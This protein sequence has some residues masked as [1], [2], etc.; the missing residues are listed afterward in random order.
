MFFEPDFSYNNEIGIKGTLGSHRYTIAA[1]QIDWE[2][3]QVNDAAAAGGWRLVA[4][5]QD[6][7]SQGLEVELAGYFGEK[8]QY[9]FGYA[10]IEAEIKDAFAVT[11]IAY[12]APVDIISTQAG[13]PLPSGPEDTITLALDYSHDAPILDDWQLRWHLNGF[14]R[15]ET[16]SGLVSL[17]PG[18]PQPFEMDGF[19]V[20]DAS[21]NLESNRKPIS[22]SLYIENI[23]NERAETGGVDQ[24]FAGPRAAYFFVG[25]PRTIGLRMNYSFGR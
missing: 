2:N 20:W 16:T 13:D 6:A 1:F 17:V 4:N 11:D 14:Y 7:E 22:V 8:L 3:V 18:D 9:S 19:S 15:S 21:L 25:R 24:N 12:G 5:G 23:G 10:H